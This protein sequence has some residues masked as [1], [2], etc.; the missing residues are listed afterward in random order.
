MRNRTLRALAL[1]LIVLAAYV[2]AFRAGYVWDDKAIYENPQLR[3]AEGLRKIWCEPSAMIP[4]EVHYWPLVHTTFWI[5]HHL[6][7]ANPAGYH[8]VNVLLHA[9]NAVLLWLLL[10]RLGV[11]AAWPA[12]AVFALHPVHAESVAWIIERKDLL[13][14]L[15]CLLSFLAYE[16]FAAKGGMRHY[17]VAAAMFVLALLSKSIAV[18]FPVALLL[19]VW[20]KHDSAQAKHVCPV[21]PFFA[22][23]G[24]FALFDVRLARGAEILGFAFS[25]VEKILIAGRALWF[26]AGKMI[27]PV[28]IMAVYPRWEIDPSNPAQYLFPA[29]ALAVLLLLWFNRRRWGKTPFAAAVFFGAALAPT[30]GFIEYGYMRYSFVADRFQYLASTGPIV[31]F[32]AAI[33]QAVGKRLAFPKYICFGA[34]AVLLG[35]YGVATWRQAATYKDKETLFRHV[36]E[37]NPESYIAHYNVAAELAKRGAHEEAVWHYRRVQRIKPGFGDTQRQLADSLLELGNLKDAETHYSAYLRLNPRCVGCHINLGNAL[38][39]QGKTEAAMMSYRNALRIEPEN[40][41]ANNNLGFCLAGKG[42]HAAALEHYSASLKASPDSLETHSNL[43]RLLLALGRAGEAVEHYRKALR[44]NP[45]HAEAL[46]NLAW[47]L[48]THRDAAL[49]NAG[50]AM[51]LAGRA[52]ELTGR[53]EASY[54]DTLAA[55]CAEAGRFEQAAQTAREAL[56]RARESGAKELTAEIARR[57][58]LYESRAPYREP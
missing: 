23:A 9:A 27:W 39:R 24:L 49:R 6:W 11:P 51:R 56:A 5:D 25:P 58:A 55:A 28:E 38:L 3:T 20:L 18:S 7:G 1:I 12:A 48:A 57:L 45:D 14:Y 42:E 26:Y 37:K 47:I 2:P 4:Y 34:L 15:F 31:L 8:V 41:L 40:P 50:E 46:N 30:L 33:G 29:A 36:L 52:C 54:L 16:R 32:A 17:A 44:L 22:I 21:L 43:A 35:L 19:W 13:S 10:L 53:Q